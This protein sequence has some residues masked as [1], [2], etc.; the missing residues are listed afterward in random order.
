MS[1]IV[2]KGH[3][4]W[5]DGSVMTYTMTDDGIL[6]ISGSLRNGS[7]VPFKSK[8]PFRHIVIENGVESVGRENFRG[9]NEL[10]ELTLP[11][12]V[13]EIGNEAFASCRNLRRIHFSEGL[14]TI[15]EEAFRGCVS[16]NGIRL[17]HTLSKIMYGAFMGC[18]ALEKVSLPK[19]I[20]LGGAVFCGCD[21]LREVALPKGLQNIPVSTFDCCRVLESIS[22]P[23]S[24]QSI[25]SLA[26]ARCDKL[27]NFK[28]PEKD[29]ITISED[30]FGNKIECEVKGEDGVNYLCTIYNIK[31]DR[32]WASIRPAEKVERDVIVPSRVEYEGKSYPVTIIDREA[33]YGMKITSLYCPTRFWK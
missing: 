12:S 7:L 22:I 24:V 17:P 28:F 4:T 1:K 16:L 21:S 15:G 30:A 25:G 31:T 9:L 5:K 33:F 3:K 29:D 27:L 19:G 8:A 2:S 13:K 26:F 14:A 18:D 11:S 6:S 32:A 10:E 23:S 20:E